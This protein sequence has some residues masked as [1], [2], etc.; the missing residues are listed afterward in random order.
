MHFAHLCSNLLTLN[1]D[2]S[3]SVL[4]DLIDRIHDTL[5]LLKRLQTKKLGF[6]FRKQVEV[7]GGQVRGNMGH[8]EK[9]KRRSLLQQP[10]QLGM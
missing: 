10:S 3:I 5:L 8:G 4:K 6:Q 7:K 9:F 1:I 2:I